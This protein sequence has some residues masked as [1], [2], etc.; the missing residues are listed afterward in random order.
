MIHPVRLPGAGL[1]HAYTN[2]DQRRA[3]CCSGIITFY[4]WHDLTTVSAAKPQLGHRDAGNNVLTLHTRPLSGSRLVSAS[5]R[6]Q[7]LLVFET[8]YWLKAKLAHGTG[9]YCGGGA[10]VRSRLLAAM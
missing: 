6:E 5:R 10:L 7:I 2:S 9:T 8:R 4:N 1:R 3:A